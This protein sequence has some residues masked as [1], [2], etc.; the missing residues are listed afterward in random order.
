MYMRNNDNTCF[1]GVGNMRD[2]VPDRNPSVIKS[3][4]TSLTYVLN[5]VETR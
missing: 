4:S 5:A 2:K 3:Y 1:T